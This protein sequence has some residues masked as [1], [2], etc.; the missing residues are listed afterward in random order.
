[1]NDTQH[2]STCQVLLHPAVC[3]NPFA[4]NAVQQRTGLLLIVTSKGRAKA[5]PR[6]AFE[7]N[8]P[9]GGDAA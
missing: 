9:F 8:G 3:Q 1:M 7:S 5:L 4:I 2:R 6:T